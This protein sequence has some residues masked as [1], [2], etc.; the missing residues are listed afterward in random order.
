MS[1][2]ALCGTSIFIDRDE[3]ITIEDYERATAPIS[4]ILDKTD[5][6]SQSYMLEVLSESGT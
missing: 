2:K 3:G 1:R 5:P 6:I 4:D